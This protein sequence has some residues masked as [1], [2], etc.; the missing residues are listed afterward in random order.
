MQATFQSADF[1]RDTDVDAR[2]RAFFEV[3]SSFPPGPPPGGFEIADLNGDG[4][5]D[6]ADR[7]LF[8]DQFRRYRFGADGIVGERDL[9][10]FLD[11]FTGPGSGGF[12]NGVL[13]L[14]DLDGDG[15]VD[16]DDQ[17]ILHS[18]LTE[19]VPYDADIDASGAVEVDDLH[20]W[21]KTPRDVNRDGVINDA[22]ASLLEEIIRADERADIQ[23]P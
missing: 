23:Y 7:V 1:N 8:E 13:H 3:A 2:D 21:Y 17:L 11:S 18:L 15:D 4:V 16:Y 14:Y 12:Q 20:E 10:A 6:H 22:D 5:L 19:P 9:R